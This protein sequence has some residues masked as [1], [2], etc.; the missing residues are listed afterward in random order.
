[1]N[2]QCWCSDGFAATLIEARSPYAATNSARAASSASTWLSASSSPLTWS[3]FVEPG[4][5]F[6]SYAWKS[7]FMPS[8]MKSG[9]AS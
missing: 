2:A 5:E 1:M 4:F 3:R 8:I 9:E 7:H 6:G